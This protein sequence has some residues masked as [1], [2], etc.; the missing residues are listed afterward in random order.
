M[1]TKTKG[2]VGD[3]HKAAKQQQRGGGSKQAA[4]PTTAQPLP[5]ENNK[6]NNVRAF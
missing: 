2:Q 6:P 3:K 1:P 5:G 4:L